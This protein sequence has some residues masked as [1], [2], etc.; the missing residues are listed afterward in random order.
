[1]A[2]AQTGDGDDTTSA[3]PDPAVGADDAD[4]VVGSAEEWEEDAALGR[5]LLKGKVRIDRED[6][7]GHLYADEV[8]MFYDPDGDSRKVDTM[9]ARGNVNLREADFLATSDTADFTDGTAVIDLTGSV[10]V[11]IDR[12]RMEADR[13]RYDRRTGKKN[14]QGNVK[15]RFRLPSQEGEAPADPAAETDGEAAGAETTDDATD[16]AGQADAE[17]HGGSED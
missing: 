6:G 13:F 17:Q 1:H 5:R 12:D 8:E 11:F 10:V 9:Q 16:A 14:A 15:F 4:W 3:S 7:S 2:P